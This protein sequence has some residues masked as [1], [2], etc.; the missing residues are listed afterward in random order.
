M[1]FFTIAPRI[2]IDDFSTSYVST[3][4]GAVICKSTSSISSTIDFTTISIFAFL[5]TFLWTNINTLVAFTNA[6][7]IDCSTN[8]FRWTPIYIALYII[9]LAIFAIFERGEK[10][11]GTVHIKMSKFVHFLF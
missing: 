8:F 5:K 4:F 11:D 10:L 6:F 7:Y 9:K 2:F 3:T 1:I